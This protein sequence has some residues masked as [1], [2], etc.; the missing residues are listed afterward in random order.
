MRDESIKTPRRK[1]YAHRRG[2]YPFLS[3]DQIIVIFEKEILSHIRIQRYLL[4]AAGYK[5]HNSSM[6]GLW[7]RDIPTFILKQL[8]MTDIWPFEDNI[9]KY[10]RSTFFTVIEF[11][12]DYVS[13]PIFDRKRTIERYE[14]ESAQD[15]YRKR[16]NELL[17]LYC[18]R[19][20]DEHNE[21]HEIF[22]ELSKFGEIHE[23]VQSGLKELIEEVPQTKDTENIDDKIQHA[24]SSFLRYGTSKEEKKDAIRTLGDVLE[25]LKKSDIKLPKKDD[26][27]LFNI[28]NNFSIHHH[29]KLQMPDYSTDEWYEFFFHLFLASINLLLKFQNDEPN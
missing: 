16:V 2:H 3:F 7:G 26:S 11:I 12:F 5:G 24:V 28:L 18:M 27:A 15:D 19:Y 21:Y 20:T 14:K 8:Q 13:E 29:D 4:E 25:Y 6:V 23:K 10:D 17:A 22:Y 1:Y 9:Q